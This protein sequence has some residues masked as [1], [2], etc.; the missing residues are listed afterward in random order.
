MVPIYQRSR[1]VNHLNILHLCLLIC[2]FVGVHS[3]THAQSEGLIQTS[4]QTDADKIRQ[5]QNVNNDSLLRVSWYYGA[6]GKVINGLDSAYQIIA[7]NIN[8]PEVTQ[9][10]QVIVAFYLD[11]DGSISNPAIV[12]SLDAECDRE[13]LRLI[14]FL[15]LKPQVSSHH[16]VK[17]RLEMMIDFN[18]KYSD[19]K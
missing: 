11:Q 15:S 2:F 19:Q 5:A 13:A 14:D 6:E 16:P 18:Q 8:I 9:G 3:M 17:I 7:D 1:S 4:W 12:Q 10:G